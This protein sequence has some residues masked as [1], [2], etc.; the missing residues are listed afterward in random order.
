MDSLVFDFFHSLAGRLA[1]LDWLIVFFAVYLPYFLIAGLLLF[2]FKS[3]RRSF[4]ARAF[5]LTEVLLSVIL[6]RGV[7]VELI[8]FFYHRPR[9]FTALGFTPLIFAESFSFPSGHVAF[10]TA[11]ALVLFS[12]SRKWGWW[13][14]GLTLFNGLTRVMAGIH[15]PSDIIAGIGVGFLSFLSVQ[16]ILRYYRKKLDL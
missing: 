1:V 14:L 11:L 4:S 16:F 13:F 5:F 15:W 7:L 6:A 2:L 9:P 8:R 12:F 10:F 3:V